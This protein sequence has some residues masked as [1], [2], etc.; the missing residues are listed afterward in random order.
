MSNGMAWRPTRERD[1]PIKHTF[2]SITPWQL[3]GHIDQ[4]TAWAPRGIVWKNT[5]EIYSHSIPCVSYHIQDIGGHLVMLCSDYTHPRN[6]SHGN[7]QSA[8]VRLLTDSYFRILIGEFVQ[9]NRTLTRRDLVNYGWEPN[10]VMHNNSSTNRSTSLP[11]VGW[12]R[13]KGSE[14]PKD[15]RDLEI[16]WTK[17]IVYHVCLAK[18]SICFETK[19]AIILRGGQ[20]PNAME[21]YSQI[22]GVCHTMKLRPSVTT[23]GS[24]GTLAIAL[25]S[26]KLQQ[27]LPILRSRPST[28]SFQTHKS[29]CQ[30]CNG[31]R[32]R[33]SYHTHLI[34][35]TNRYSELDQQMNAKLLSHDQEPKERFLTSQ[36][37]KGLQ[38]IVT[39]TSA[40]ALVEFIK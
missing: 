40:F 36:N 18:T 12:I 25:A 1:K 11:R 24:T 19:Q 20:R 4:Q 37:I 35:N 26:A 2:S 27:P 7:M 34:T 3:V 17:F 30:I 28:A 38:I 32:E 33:L 39:Q 15:G 5:Q 8:I 10:S 31:Y 16:H 14:I 13:C 6:L 29:D 23:T 21:R 9:C 22:N